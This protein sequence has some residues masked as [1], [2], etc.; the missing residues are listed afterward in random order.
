MRV[1]R[2]DGLLKVWPTPIADQ[3]VEYVAPVPE[4][5][6]LF[7]TTSVRGGS[8]AIPTETSA[9]VF[10]WDTAK[11]E[12]VFRADPVPGTET[13]GRAVRG[14]NGLIYGLAEKRYYVFDPVGRSIVFTGELPVKS[15]R[16]PHLNREPVG[17]RGLIVGLGDDAVYCIDPADNSARVLA[18]HPSIGSPG[19]GGAHGFFVT[20]DGVLYYGSEATLMRYRLA[21]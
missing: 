12:M 15:L 11:E 1:N 17:P 10:L 18:R 13:Y 5:G 16:F 20:P 7:C 6:E 3:S 8:S 9:C 19:K 14:R 2:K 4:T 21:V